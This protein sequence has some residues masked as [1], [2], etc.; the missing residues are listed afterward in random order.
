MKSFWWVRFFLFLLP[1]LFCCALIFL[2]VKPLLFADT[3]LVHLDGDVSMSTGSP[4]GGIDVVSSTQDLTSNV[5]TFTG[6]GIQKGLPAAYSGGET[7]PGADMPF[8]MVQWGPD[9]VSR[10]YSGYKYSDNR[11]RGFSLTH[12]SGAGC[13][14]Y[15]DVPFMPV[16]NTFTVAP[17]LD[18]TRYI[19][20]FVHANETAFP[21][22]YRLKMDNGV[23]T[24]LTVTPRSGAGR[25][26]YPVGQPASML[27]NLSG[28][29]TTVTDAQAML[30]RDTISGWVNNGSFCGTHWNTY[31]LYFWA[32]FSRPFL[33]NGT[34][35]AGTVNPG[36]T[37]TSGPNTGVFVSFDTRKQNFVSVR[38]GVS[39]VSVTNARANVDQEN[40]SDNFDALTQR[41]EQTWNQ[42]LE[43]IQISGGTPVQQATFYT[44][45][46]HSLL[47]PSVFSDINGQYIGFDNKL[48]HVVSGH[49]QYA[50]FSGWDMYRSEAQLLALLAPDQAADMAQSLVNDGTQG[51]GLPKWPIANSETYVQVGDPATAIIADIYAFGGTD[52]DTQA[53]L[54]AMVRQAT[55]SSAE[56]PG[57]NY[58]TNLGY[59]PIGAAY[60]CCNFY[61]SA[62]TSLEYN[63]A[64]F[65]LSAFAGA[66]GASAT[67]QR[68]E[69]RAQGWRKLFDAS[70]GYLQP[71]RA[72]GSFE[73]GESLADNRG[74]I[75]GNAA[76]YTWMVPFNLRGLFDAI[77]GNAQVVQ[78][79]DTFFTQLNVGTDA[80]YAFMGNE[81][82]IE[83]PWE[84]DYAGAP[85]KTQS[86]VRKILNTLWMP[87]ANGLPGNDDLG[88]MSSW[89]VFAAL[90]LFPE[91]PGTANLVLTTPLFPQI[92]LH[93]PG[94]QVIQ[95]NAPGASDSVYYIQSLNVDGMPSQA[96]WLPATF[97]ANGGTLDYE[98]AAASNPA[99]GADPV[100]A[101]P[102]YA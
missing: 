98:L 48:H 89:Y 65:A 96:P 52:F 53:A 24:E 16:A 51:G 35:R 3:G 8:G 27:L 71:R 17:A 15:G 88:E 80:P 73:R 62:S 18:P 97:I 28:S 34:W 77:G 42:W 56:R 82:S 75:E 59:E 61:G 68:F 33:S 12:L 81:P 67:Q 95:I 46:Y 25:F 86:I 39:Y 78:R 14:A 40:P 23:T 58:L 19:S 31:R 57:L 36:A 4:P 41:S 30:G 74:W 2:L 54:K 38:V 84:Y 1:V 85:Y 29:L 37:T 45:L 50:N 87:G 63:S 5:N 13:F 66:L 91:T 83:I 79:L 20:T 92:T 7:F 55:Q 93:R 90:G 72:D 49:A 69:Q 11:I 6:T 22:F 43:K 60:N 21:G 32:Q 101:P 9:T 70:T 94:G 100:D 26:T 64:D 44:A 47:F 102:S 10:A 76:Q 99:W